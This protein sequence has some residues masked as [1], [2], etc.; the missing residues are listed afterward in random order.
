MVHEVVD[1]STGCMVHRLVSQVR[2]TPIAKFLDC[3]FLEWPIV[4]A[5]RFQTNGEFTIIWRG[6][7]ERMLP[8]RSIIVIHILAITGHGS[9]QGLMVV[10]VMILIENCTLFVQLREVIFFARIKISTVRIYKVTVSRR[11]LWILEAIC[12]VLASTWLRLDMIQP[13]GYLKASF[14]WSG[15]V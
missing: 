1:L 4:D 14:V 12:I 11:V 15:A 8:F 5:V 7:T 10:L 2:T 3:N 13:L 9:Y 6:T